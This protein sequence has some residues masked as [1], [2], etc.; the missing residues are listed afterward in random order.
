MKHFA[1]GLTFIIM[2]SCGQADI[3][4]GPQADNLKVEEPNIKSETF[5]DEIITLLY[6]KLDSGFDIDFK[7]NHLE[8]IL[9]NLDILSLKEGEEFEKEMLFEDYKCDC[10]DKI[11]IYYDKADDRF[12][13]WVYEEFY[14]TDLDWCP[15]TSYSYSFQ[16]VNHKI[17]D[18]KLDFMAG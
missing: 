1:F 16:I 12:I 4:S 3:Q 15:E 9:K 5:D 14:E 6:E 10:L 18:L 8:S 17:T 13:L 2:T 7:Q 11:K